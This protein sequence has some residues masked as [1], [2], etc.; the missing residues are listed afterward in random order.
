MSG[1]DFRRVICY[2]AGYVVWPSTVIGLAAACAGRRWRLRKQGRA[3]RALVTTYPYPL[4]E[5]GSPPD[6][7]GGKARAPLYRVRLSK[8]RADNHLVLRISETPIVRKIRVVS[9]CNVTSADRRSPDIPNSGPLGPLIAN[10]GHSSIALNTTP[11][12][13][14]LNRGCCARASLIEMMRMVSMPGTIALRENQWLQNQRSRIS[15]RILPRAS[16][17]N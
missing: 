8:I 13:P 9:I 17:A 14:R 6:P 10:S 15:R 12:P 7:M 11:F 3:D 4:R 2:S 16:Y 5:I 1:P